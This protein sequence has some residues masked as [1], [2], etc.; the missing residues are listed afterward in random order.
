MRRCGSPPAVGQL[1][2]EPRSILPPEVVHYDG[3]GAADHSA[4]PLEDSNP[5]ALN[6][7]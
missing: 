5:F 3:K 6:V 1:Q 4:V 2:Y 7:E